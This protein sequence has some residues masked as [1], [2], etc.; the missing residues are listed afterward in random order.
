MIGQTISHYKIIEKL[1]EGGMGVVYKA[2]DLT[3]RR[4]VALKF[5]PERVSASEPDKARFMQEAQAAAALNHPNICTIYGI[6]E[7]DGQTFIAME[8]V[9]GQTLREK[10]G[11][12]SF[13]QAIDIGI[14]L[15][16][17]LAVAHEKGIVHRDIKPDNIMIRK[18]GIAQI[19]DFGL[20]KLRGVSRLTKEGSTVGTAGYMS[21]EQVH[22]QE[23]DHR[24]DI[25]SL[26]V[27]LYELCTGQI[28]FKGLHETAL[29]YEIVNVDAAPMSA[30]K[31]DLDPELDRIVLECLEKEPSE[32]YQSAAEISKDLKRFKRESGRQK[33]GR[34]S[35]IREASQIS[36][37]SHPDDD[38]TS[39]RSAKRER[40][41]VI[42]SV[43][44]FFISAALTVLYMM[45]QS[46]EVQSVQAM[47]LP[48][49]KF[50]FSS[51]G[52]SHI[53][54]S[55]NG[56]MLA[57]VA[58]DSSGKTQLY[59]R[60]L[61]S[62]V[63]QLLAGTEG[64][65]YPFWSPDSRFIGFF[66]GNKLKKIEAGGGP[67]LTICDAN[68]GRGGSW[69]QDGV[70]VFSPDVGSSISAVTAAGGVPAAITNLDSSRR[71]QTHRWPYFLPDGKHFLYFAR[72]VGFENEG[73]A[74]YVASLD[75][76]LNK[77]IL[78][79]HSNSVYVNGHILFMRDRTLLAQPFDT[80]NFEM[81]GD[82][83]PVAEQVQYDLAF[84]C[85]V[86]SAS[87]NGHLVYQASGSQTGFDL[88]L[89]DRTGKQM[90]S[91]IEPGLYY[92]PTFS[93]DMKKLAMMY[94]DISSHN[95]DVWILE[96]SRGI[97]TRLTFDLST[98]RNPIWSPDGT[99]IA[100]CSDR[101]GRYDI[102]VKASSGAAT[103][104]GLL[105]SNENKVTTD[106][107]SDG[108][109][110]L[111]HTFGDPKT[112]SDLWVLPLTGERKPVSFLQTDY[113]ESSGHF[114]SDM[115]WIAYQSDESGKNEVYVRPFPGPG[116]KWQVSTN[117][118]T[119][120]RWRRDGREVYYFSPDSKMM[121]AEVKPSGS[122]FEVSTVKTLFDLQSKGQSQFEAVNPDGQKFL[123]KITGG[124]ITSAPLT[125]VMNWME[126]LKKK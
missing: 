8:F 52:G 69:S 38:G 55:P 120:S 121:A 16:D 37:V 32:R 113:N 48:P 107:S 56:K 103:E 90:S 53:A 62:L 12:I 1:G 25:F 7:Q 67:A 21:P 98:D 122:A 66:A 65:T 23:A 24:S 87:G 77:R 86:F 102:Y 20:A 104:E 125:L 76:A 19:M 118:G 85:G 84:T 123:I 10:K 13:K 110:I 59:V 83:V 17:G 63:V 31:P 43:L 78:S 41:A 109:Y 30:V 93:H 71:E 89:F 45:R 60:P 51:Q 72:A 79:V 15:A 26:G 44:F 75:R 73:D 101:Q 119:S 81:L 29:A 9:D 105:V 88:F 35:V 64:A 18:D 106:W 111:Y 74:I 50:R 58:S 92:T 46:P 3:L 124:G 4:M 97:K 115:K 100:F 34:T 40:I 49:E 57:F 116:G 6:E 14:Q 70:I 47:I 42:A 114:S 33:I 28:P 80:K 22:G 39:L 11:S 91:L 27:L 95:Q 82:A 99:K 61:R 2:E 126:E 94:L 36:Q 5:L 96:L 68:S 108:N 54:L 112:K 117:G